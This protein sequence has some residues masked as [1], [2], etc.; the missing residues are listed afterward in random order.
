MAPLCLD[1][2]KE[3]ALFKEAK[4]VRVYTGRPT[5]RLV[6]RDAEYHFPEAKEYMREIRLAKLYS[7]R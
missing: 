5:L 2:E 1:E 4:K 6:R 3:T 7:N